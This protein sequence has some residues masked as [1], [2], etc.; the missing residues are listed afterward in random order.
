MTSDY[1]TSCFQFLYFDFGKKETD[2]FLPH[3]VYSV[4][5]GGPHGR[6]LQIKITCIIIIIIIIIVCFNIRKESI[7]NFHQH[8][9]AFI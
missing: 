4:S 8:S 1:A 7:H 3:Y 9:A 5:N 2:F 6:T